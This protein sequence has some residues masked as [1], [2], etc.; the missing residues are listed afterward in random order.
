MAENELIVDSSMQSQA[1]VVEDSSGHEA[2]AAPVE[3]QQKAPAAE[4]MISQSE[5]GSTIARIKKETAEKV[6]A[7]TMAQFE[8]EKGLAQQAQQPGQTQNMGGVQQQSQEQIRRLIQ[9]EAY[10]M[11]QQ[12]YAQQIE[13]D[14]LSKIESEKSKDPEFAELYDELNLEAHPDLVIWANS[15]DNTGSVVK[16]LANNPTKFSHILMLARSG[17]PKMAKKE[18]EKLSASIKANE[19]A[20]Q[21]PK[22]D[23]PLSQLKPTNI[24]SD[25]GDLS[26]SDYRLMF[27]G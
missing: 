7:E 14:Y 11:S 19:A 13:R 25:N 12:S 27:K 5:F 23:A 17:S 18:F 15:L 20:Q 8:R 4:K 24:G 26:V 10:K 2:I 1:P 3:S 21:Q 22:I 9:E 6:R 16:D